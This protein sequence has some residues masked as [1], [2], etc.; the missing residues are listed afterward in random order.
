MA[1][2]LGLPAIGS[3]AELIGVD[4]DEVPGTRTPSVGTPGPTA[5]TPRTRT[6][7]EELRRGNA[8]LLAVREVDFATVQRAPS[9]EVSTMYPVNNLPV[10]PA[11]GA[12]VIVTLVWVKMKVCT[13]GAAAVGSGVPETALEKAPTPI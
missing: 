10:S 13:T 12:H 1:V 11:G 5:V 9:S 6:K 4:P 7:N 8:M 2:G 3:G